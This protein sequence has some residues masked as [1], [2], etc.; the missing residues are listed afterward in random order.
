MAEENEVNA[1]QA[2]VEPQGNTEQ[3][4]ENND[5]SNL[6][7]LSK[8][9]AQFPNL[10][11]DDMRAVL[12]KPEAKVEEVKKEEVPVAETK[13]EE[14]KTEEV[15][16]DA[17]DV[18]GLTKKKTVS[19][20]FEGFEDFMGVIKEKHS[21]DDPSTLITSIDKWRKGSQKASEI[22]EKH[23]ALLS[24]LDALPTDLKTSVRAY[25]NG[26]DYKAAFGDAG[27]LLDYSKD[28]NSHSKDDLTKTYFSD[29]IAKAKEKLSEGDID[30]DDY[31]ERI[32][33][34]HSLS[35]RLYKSDKLQ[36]EKQ[37]ADQEK[38]QEENIEALKTSAISSVENLRKTL[39]NFSD[40]EFKKV[41]QRL[42]SQDL[43]SIFFDKNGRYK[44][45]AAEKIAMAI[46]GKEV[47]SKLVERASKEAESKTT[48]KF[49]ER[50]NTE[51][52]AN[53]AVGTTSNSGLEKELNKSFG[54]M[55]TNDVYS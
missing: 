12:N 36:Y 46:Y 21:I 42:V 32:D 3:F 31:T 50:G 53:K 1:E 19:K 15:E 45:D 10:V 4:I 7:H 18:F 48:Q 29:R 37:R 41:R 26:E 28:F 20:E 9:A 33:D 49:V 17:G 22:E 6:D 11:D 24:D 43:S 35:E 55:F 13:A 39:P 30:E 51:L 2:Q 47:I 40:N 52:K 38:K 34:L 54:G 44:A 23:N 27:T 14:T 8:M 5:N 25:A 16:E